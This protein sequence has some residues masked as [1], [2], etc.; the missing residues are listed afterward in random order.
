MAAVVL[1]SQLGYKPLSM[2]SG[3]SEWQRASDW[4]YCLNGLCLAVLAACLAPTLVLIGAAACWFA[5]F[6]G[7]Q[8][9]VC[10]VAWMGRADHPTVPVLSGLCVVQFGT[11]AYECGLA[12]LLAA[13][14][15]AWKKK[16]KG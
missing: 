12:A 11:R 6:E 1:L 7:A 16:T 14:A 5:A 2:I 15:V 3:D 13:G 9:F 10:G 4:F 8:T